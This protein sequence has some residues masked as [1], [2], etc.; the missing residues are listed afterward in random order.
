MIDPPPLP[1]H[2]K[3]WLGSFRSKGQI[4]GDVV[5]PVIDETQWEV[6]GEQVPAGYAYP[7]VEFVG[8]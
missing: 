7:P 8:T 4:I 5:S 3:S 2:K 1:E 6:P